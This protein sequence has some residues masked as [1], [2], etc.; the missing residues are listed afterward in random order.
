MG[1]RPGWC[2]RKPKRPAYTRI[3]NKKMKKAFIRGVPGIRIPLFDMGNKSK[4]QWK[5]EIDLISKDEMQLRHNQLEAARQTINKEL[6]NIYSKQGFFMRLRTYPHH[7][8]REN[9]IATGAGADRFQRGMKKSFGKP[10]GRA[11]RVKPG[12]IIFSIWVDN[13]DK[14]DII[15]AAMRRAAQKM[16]G[17]YTIKIDKYDG[18]L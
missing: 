14:I 10:I 16:S 18:T 13:I 11:A 4:R 2:Y 8:M 12:S 3:A 6:V 15:K 17:Q 9:P 5:Y 1:L 7:V